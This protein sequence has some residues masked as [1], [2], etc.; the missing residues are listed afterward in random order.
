[1][2]YLLLGQNRFNRELAVVS[3]RRTYEGGEMVS[4]Q[5]DQGLDPWYEMVGQSDLFGG[6]VA[7]V[8]RDQ[9]DE[10]NKSDLEALSRHLLKNGVLD[11]DGPAVV[12]LGNQEGVARYPGL[13]EELVNGAKVRVFAP[14]S[15]AE[16][17]R[18]ATAMAASLGVGLKGAQATQL[19]AKLDCN[20]FAI[21]NQLRQWGLLKK[22]TISVQDLDEV[23]GI[24]GEM[25]VF[26]LTEAWAKRDLSRALEELSLL[27]A[28][29]T[30][31]PVIIGALGWQ[32]EL[33]RFQLLPDV[34]EEATSTAPFKDFSLRQ[35]KKW[36]RGW[37]LAEVEAAVADLLQL[38]GA[39]KTGRVAGGVGL[40]VL[41]YSH[42]PKL[43]KVE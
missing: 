42:L 26:G 30:P 4:L 10:W 37:S 6:E 28:Q 14:L 35:A 39:L 29:A 9:L 21:L 38:D 31:V 27:Q 36:A 8:G 5:A 24:E 12:L 23:I 17:Q 15:V 18:W 16:A 11:K 25:M 40:E 43:S 34:V 3:L 19:V 7:V 22:K 13:A 20:Q 2:L 33:L 32:L 41:L 1:M